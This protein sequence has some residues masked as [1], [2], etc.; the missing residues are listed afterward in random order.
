MRVYSR[1][2]CVAL[3]GLG[4]GFLQSCGDT[5]FDPH[6]TTAPNVLREPISL[7]SDG[8][9]QI[10]SDCTDD[11]FCFQNRCVR[12]CDTDAECGEGN[13]CSPRGRCI[14]AARAEAA[15]AQRGPNAPIIDEEPLSASPAR[16][17]ANFFAVDFPSVL[18]VEEGQEYVRFTVETEEPVPEGRLLY[19]VDLEGTASEPRVYRAEGSTRFEIE[20]PTGVAGTPLIGDETRLQF[21]Y[22][23]TSYGGKSI[24]LRP[25]VETSG[26][27]RGNVTMREF[28]TGGLPFEIG[29]RLQPAGST[30]ETAETR[31]LLLPVRAAALFSP[32]F[33]DAATEGSWL[34][35]PLE[36][37]AHTGV[38]YARFA[39]QFGLPLDYL[40]GERH[41]LQRNMRIEI[42]GTEE[43]TLYGAISD[44]WDGLFAERS[45]DG[46]TTL[47][48]VRL[49]GTWEAQRAGRF[50][51]GAAGVRLG[52]GSLPTP[53]LPELEVDATCSPALWTDLRQRATQRPGH[54]ES[55]D[56]FGTIDDLLHGESAQ[57]AS[58]VLAAA[59]VALSGPT[60]VRQVAAFLSPE[61]EN[62]GGLS[63]DDFL[64]R[65]ALQQGYCTPSPEVVCAANLSAL[66]YQLYDY[67]EA[68]TPA[69]AAAHV[70]ALLTRYQEL[71]RETYLGRQLAAYRRDSETRLEW[72]RS[73][74]APLFLA[75]ELR[76]YNQDIMTRW[77][78]EV[79]AAHFDVLARQY[80]PADLEVLALVPSDEE[81]QAARRSLLLEL[82]QTWQGAMEAT[83]LAATRWNTIHQNDTKRAA[84]AAEVR[85]SMLEFYLS[86]A[87]L[88]HL[89]RSA[90]ST[91]FNAQLGSGFS[92]LMRELNELQLPYNDLIFYRDAEVALSRSVDPNSD[93]NSLL[94]ERQHL[95]REAVR[96]A[97][98]TVDRVLDEA[99]ETELNERVLMDNMHTQLEALR[100]ELVTL[101]GVPAGCATTDVGVLPECS[102]RTATAEC[103]FG[104]DTFGQIPDDIQLETVLA[105]E[106]GS[107]AMQIH[108]ALLDVAL[109]KEEYRATAEQIAILMENAEAFEANL[110][111]WNVRR[112][113]VN[114]EIRQ[115]LNDIARLNSTHLQQVATRLSAIQQARERAYDRQSAALSQWHSLSVAGNQE[116]YQTML[117]INHRRMNAMNLEVGADLVADL[118]DAWVEGIPDSATSIVPGDLAQSAVLAAGAAAKAA[119]SFA[120]VS[121]EHRAAQ[122][123]A[124][125]EY[126]QAMRDTKV[127]HLQSL[128]EL[129]AQLSENRIEELAE[130]LR[131]LELETDAE[132]AAREALIDTLRRNL[133]ADLAY[134]HDLQELRD[135]QRDIHIKATELPALA[136]Q[137]TQAEIAAQQRVLAYDAIVQRAQLLEGR[138][139]AMNARAQNL[140][141]LLGSPSVIF[142]F[143][144]RLVSAESRIEYAKTQLFEWLVA[145]EY[146]AVRPFTDQRVA[147]TLA[148]NPSQLSAIA[149]DLQRLQRL[150]GGIVNYETV[151]VSVRDQLLRM[152][153]DTL[154]HVGEDIHV[155]RPGA[156]FRALLERGNVPLSTQIRYSSDERVG[157]LLTDR[158]VWALT[159]PIR[160][161][162]FANL[163]LSCNAKLQSIAVQ[164]VGDELEDELLPVVSVLYD[165]TSEL[166]SCQPDIDMLVGAL[167]PGATSFG[168]VTR[169]R[170]AGRAVAPVARV[171]AYGPEGSENRGLEGLPLSSTYTLLIDHAMGDNR[172]LSWEALDDIRLKF[173]Y[174]YQDVFPAEQCQ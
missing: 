62:P 28:G 25:K 66:S 59:D 130:E 61:E 73:S 109:A 128:A 132:I 34:A 118:V 141:H 107:A 72:L 80:S 127:T 44:R 93:S 126:Q 47:A 9:C 40:F 21:A 113:N 106:A 147:I 123:G 6:A 164:L 70:H 137:I 144:N 167:D 170:T 8:A 54:G 161:T 82:S 68:D 32:E 90:G 101:C 150:C 155:L 69:E 98:R 27:Y 11:L 38:W 31:E 148:R 65:C 83:Q 102:V 103:G 165:G 116:D 60:T 119:L 49:S 20:I 84:A 1:F 39:H 75:A 76:S 79:L 57:R 171:N 2:L 136:A 139:H 143:T 157:D 160:L 124:Q 52:E 125:L 12:E 108:S 16:G 129:D 154:M 5:A 64:E 174:A 86:A 30:L 142:A 36:Y 46:I 63:F 87:A 117:S 74:I 122:L 22:V 55:C 146:Y 110:E 19:R 7:A 71:S 77:E 43:H 159:F 162:D 37:D 151:D 133:E 131:V 105:S 78:N 115:T 114:H 120:A 35:R 48:P 13:L 24:T 149:D 138:F 134:E 173:T 97:E 67:Q 4:A 53:P 168:R 26:V 23:T 135:R 140:H 50:A 172:H 41:H 17:D 166:L 33:P 18:E 88:S 51:P 42:T 81:S 91:A 169:F 158:D 112:R 111:Q 58:C 104:V 95:A 85:R 10:D 99:H 94:S 14:D 152:N 89:N 153:T 56:G 100:S 92:A 163:P 145:L 3:L 45:A 29:L 121:Q 156:R 96:S 15:D